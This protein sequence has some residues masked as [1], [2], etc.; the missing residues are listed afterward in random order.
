M[1][2][3]RIT[4]SDPK[5]DL[6]RS[7]K[8]LIT[9]LGIKVKTCPKKY[10]KARY[11]IGNVSMKELSEIIS[12]FEKSPYESYERKRLKHEPTD[13]YFYLAIQL[14]KCTMR[15]D[16]L[17]LHVLPI[18]TEMAGTK[19]I[20]IPHVC[21]TDKKNQRSSDWVKL[22]RRSVLWTRTNQKYYR[23]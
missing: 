19:Q 12:E 11:V 17:T 23:Q 20:P 5:D 8:G 16:A 7:G 2:K 3:M 14:V 10:R 4:S 6:G 9:S 21:S 13:S 18:R 15:A 22:Y 1:G